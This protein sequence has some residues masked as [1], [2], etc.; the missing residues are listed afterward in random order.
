MSDR[1]VPRLSSLAIRSLAAVILVA[2]VGIIVLS[3]WGMALRFGVFGNGEPEVAG[4][5]D[6]A[7]SILGNVASAAVGG[8]VGWLTRDIVIKE[9][10]DADRA[11]D[12][13]GWD[14]VPAGRDGV[15][16]LPADVDG[17]AAGEAERGGE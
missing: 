16:D 4:N 5:A 9:G 1:A 13:G 12:A 17:R 6:E 14:G 2:L 3:L 11:V 10:R 15:G 7:L 8:L